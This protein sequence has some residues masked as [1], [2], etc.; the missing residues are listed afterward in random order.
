[1]FNW[2]K[3]IWEGPVVARTDHPLFGPMELNRIR[4]EESWD[5]E[6]VS[7]GGRTVAAYFRT[8]E[9]RLPS[10]A[11]IRFLRDTI[12]SL[13]ATFKKAEA[14]LAPAYEEIYG[15]FAGSLS[16]IFELAGVEVPLD[17]NPSNPW[18]LQFETLSGRYALFTVYFRDGAAVDFQLDT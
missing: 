4:G 12:G 7:I 2:L 3:Q 10:E 16:E 8:S 5:A 9:S 15:S 1:M 14:V 18:M 6:S 17:G 13:D 11:Q